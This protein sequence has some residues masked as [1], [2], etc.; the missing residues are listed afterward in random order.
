LALTDGG[1]LENLGVQT[2]L[3]SRRFAAWNL[4]ISDAGRKEQAWAPGGFRQYLRGAL[5]GIVCFPIIE[6]VTVMMSS[7]EN[8]H[9]R[10]SAF[11]D[12]E[13]TWLVEALR[14]NISPGL[15]EYL[16]GQRVAPRRRILYIRLEQ[17]LRELL[18]N[19]PLWR[20]RELA[21]RNG[22]SMAEQRPA[23]RELLLQLGIDLGPALEIHRAMGGDLRIDELN[24]INT[25][26]TALRTRDNEDLIAHARWQVHATHALF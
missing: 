9:M 3:K 11:G 12:L 17:T 25:H 19:I 6:R 23:T 15:N 13:R 7:K 4:V 10:V 1:V 8:R 21:A 20:L 2:L 24:R 22:R 26:F 5:M 18:A 16:D 14:G